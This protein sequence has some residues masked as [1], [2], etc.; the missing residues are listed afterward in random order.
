MS[1]THTNVPAPDAS[2][3]LLAR[4]LGRDLQRATLMSAAY[5]VIA[6]A[7]FATIGVL[8]R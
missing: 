4:F 2:D 1:D 6:A 8:I 5:L 7:V 3:E